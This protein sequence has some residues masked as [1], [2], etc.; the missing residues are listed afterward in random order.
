MAVGFHMVMTM[1]SGV[2]YIKWYLSQARGTSS[3]LSE[4]R[5]EEGMEKGSEKWSILFLLVYVESNFK[6]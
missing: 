3:S 4:G 5:E 1:E 6:T 2:N